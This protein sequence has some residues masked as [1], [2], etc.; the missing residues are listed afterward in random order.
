MTYET[1]LKATLAADATLLALLTGGVYAQTELK[2][3]GINRTDHAAAFT[4][5][6]VLKPLVIIK[7]RTLIPFGSIKKKS[8]Q[9]R[10]LR[11]TVE[12]WL[13][14]D[15]D[16]GWSVLRNAKNRILALLD[17]TRVSGGFKCELSGGVLEFR[18]EQDEGATKDACSIRIEFNVVGY[19]DN[20]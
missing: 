1:T 2:R 17:Q 19:R 14:D 11:Q 4:A 3:K 15:G 5:A 16:A 8:T 13:H 6:G 10:T 9:Y 18:A 20:S 7:G 12:L